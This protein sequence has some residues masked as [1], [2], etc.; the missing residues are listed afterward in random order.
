[1]FAR[2]A[3]LLRMR[4]RTSFSTKSLSRKHSLSTR[5]S[6]E[7]SCGEKRSTTNACSHPSSLLVSDRAAPARQE[8]VSATQHVSS[9]HH[10]G[11]NWLATRRLQATVTRLSR[12][13][14][15]VKRGSS[16]FVLKSSG[17]T[18][19]SLFVLLKALEKP[20]PGEHK[21]EPGQQKP[22]A[23]VSSRERQT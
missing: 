6:M 23:H 1:M 20:A 17:Q 22:V 3:I 21:P 4:G 5:R 12:E 10:H 14:S 11:D 7:P 13:E 18:P 8:T 19:R 15:K 2:R 9:T 16:R